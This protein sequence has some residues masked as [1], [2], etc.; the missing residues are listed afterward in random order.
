MLLEEIG[1]NKRTI[2][3]LNKKNIY[4][5]RELACYF[6]MKYLDYR[7]II[8]L[9]EAVGK[10]CAIVGYLSTY[11]KRE[12]NGRTVIG[13]DI[14]EESTGEIVHV[15]WYGQSWQFKGVQ[16]FSRKEVVV[17]GKVTKH[18]V[19]G[20][21]IVNPY[22]YHLRVNYKGRIIPIYRKIKNVSDDMLRKS[23]DKCISSLQEPLRKEVVERTKLMSYPDALKLMHHPV[24][25]DLSMSVDELIRPAG[26]RIAF[27]DMLY[28]TL[29]LKLNSEQD[30]KESPYVAK[31]NKRT[32]EIIE[33]L[34]YELTKDQLDTF[35]KIRKQ[36]AS[37]NRVNLLVQGDV[38]CGKTMIAFLS[39]FLMAE[40]GFQSV[41]LAPT[42]VLAKQH[43]EELSIHA[44]K[45]GFKVAFLC[46]EIKGKEKKEILSAIKKGEY[47]FIVG[48][49]SVFS[50]EVIYDSLALVITDEEHRFGVA[51][52]QALEEKADAGVH[53]ISMSA[54]PIPRTIADVLY[55][56]QKE[57]ATIKTMPH[58]RIPVQT[59]INRSDERIFEFM[60]K[61]LNQGRQA[62]VVCPLV[63]EAEEDSVIYGV[64]SVESTVIK[65]K[66]RFEPYGA[67]V[68]VVT[69]QMEKKE[70]EEEI[71]KFRR[72]EYQ[73][74][75]S[76][77][78]I[79]VGVNVPNASLIV[80]NN[81]ERF[82]LAQLH[83]LRGRVGRGKHK[84]YCILKSEDRE[85]ERLVTME[86]TTDGFEIAKADLKQRGFGDLL[87]T[88]QSGNNHYMDLVMSMPNLY[89]SVKK[90]AEWLLH[91]KMETE[92]MEL[93]EENTGEEE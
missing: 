52:R 44:E 48:T 13:A 39:M 84:S 85:N 43:Y 58:G 82:G 77:T 71:E 15:K 7:Q 32:K 1:L 91:A 72:N 33:S 53:V 9:T 86:R 10:D 37:G 19:Y 12:M 59:A 60:A 4:T 16:Q 17:C 45:F 66:E 29:R 63:E 68:G 27:N 62:Y 34:P 46:G 14:I 89:N 42:V 30:I 54:T 83:Q 61:Q 6:P 81:A 76:T 67:H 87:G 69:G 50:K 31:C 25:E 93:Y 38:S 47:Q 49:H 78:V 75:I 2:N 56:E 51:Q 36:T 28:F 40:N 41:L 23:I 88:A 80:I 21:S 92:I 11:E 70:I 90:Y 5:V 74:L 22:S 79:E 20:Y 24:G 8:P 64:E 18:V 65:Y 35:Y 57:I 3:A 73:I 26:N 55:G